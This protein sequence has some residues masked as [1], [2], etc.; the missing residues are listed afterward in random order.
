MKKRRSKSNLMLF[1]TILTCG[2]LVFLWMVAMLM[3][4]FVSPYIDKDSSSPMSIS[5]IPQYAV[6][7]TAS[8]GVGLYAF[9]ALL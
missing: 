5:S 8:F 1:V 4:G 7:S 6:I 2:A 3:E 9:S